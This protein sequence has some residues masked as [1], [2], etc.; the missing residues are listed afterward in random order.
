MRNFFT[1][2]SKETFFLSQDV[3]HNDSLKLDWMFKM[4]IASDIARVC[5]K[6]IQAKYS[7][8]STPPPPPCN[9]KNGNGG[10]GNGN[11]I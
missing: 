1:L 2:Y 10:H 6:L 4:S 3:L 7:L 9:F 11:F 8:E 5:I